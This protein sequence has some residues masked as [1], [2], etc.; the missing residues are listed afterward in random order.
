MN[1]SSYASNGYKVANV[2]VATDKAS[3]YASL[4]VATGDA[5]YAVVSAP[6]GKSAAD[7][8]GFVTVSG[9]SVV[10]APII[11]SASAI[12]APDTA[13]IKAPTGTYEVTVFKVTKTATSTVDNATVTSVTKASFV[14]DDHQV[15]ADKAY[16]KTLSAYTTLTAALA[17]KDDIVT[18]TINGTNYNANIQT[19]APFAPTTVGT[20]AAGEQFALTGLVV[21]VPV[22]YNGTT[23]YFFQEVAVGTTVT[24]AK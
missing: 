3:A 19:A 11:A 21:K 20:P 14:V 23:G 18:I 24:L 10:V 22:K 7:I 2:S 5:F 1:L 8:A 13:F 9:G 4:G 16:N 6:S 15:V 12:T 17:D